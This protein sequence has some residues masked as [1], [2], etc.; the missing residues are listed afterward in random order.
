MIQDTIADMLTRIRNALAV[1]HVE[2]SMF[3]SK[4]KVAIAK[5]LKEEGYIENYRIENEDSVKKVLVITLKYYN[6]RPVIERIERISKP[7]L[8]VYAD[9]KE[10]STKWKVLNGFGIA[11]IS[12]PLGLLTNR[13]AFKSKVG[14]EVICVIQ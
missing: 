9:S 5:I 14:G 1:G 7:S 6:N 8:R 11:I 12:T 13:Q 2:V 3:S 10:M 4:M